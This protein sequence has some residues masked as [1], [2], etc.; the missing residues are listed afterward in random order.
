LY[1]FVSEAAVNKDIQY[2]E[3]QTGLPAERAL[4][5]A[6]AVATLV[7]LIGGP[8]AS[9]LS[10]ISGARKEQ[11]VLEVIQGVSDNLRDFQSQAADE[12][13]KT[14]DFEE[15]LENT[16]RRAAQERSEEKRSLYGNI[17]T[18]AIKNQDGDCEEQLRLLKT[19]EEISPDH[20]LILRALK[21]TPESEVGMIGSP[22]QTLRKRV[23]DLAEER[24]EQLLNELNDLRL[25][26]MGSLRTIMTAQGAADLRHA[27]TQ[28]GQRFLSYIQRS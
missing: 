8:V 12:Y 14:D 9:I 3:V 17:I 16:L 25:T 7:P 27:V 28:Y 26:S 24:I 23:P 2:E 10:G 4:E 20:V 21:Q 1:S 22:M 19:L 5:V 6:A 18:N 15:L 11:R 13:V